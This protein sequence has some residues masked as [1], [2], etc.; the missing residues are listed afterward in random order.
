MVSKIDKLRKFEEFEEQILPAL[1]GHLKAG[2]SA[3]QLYKLYEALAAARQLTIALTE[4]DPGKALAAI[5]DIQNRASGKPKEKLEVQHRYANLS[6][7]E[8]D[9]L[10]DS[11]TK[12]VGPIDGDE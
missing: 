1:R 2:A 7:D 9:A 11:R 6:D 10:I 4:Q 8:L 5:I 12:E 3:A